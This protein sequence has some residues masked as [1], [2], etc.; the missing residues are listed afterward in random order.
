[1]RNNT[2]KA[3]RVVIIG[4]GG[5]GQVVADH[6]RN[7]VDN[8]GPIEVIG[9]LDDDVKLHHAVLNNLSVLGRVD[10][11]PSIDHD[12]VVVAIGDNC[13]R[14]QMFMQLQSSGE[15]FAVVIHSSAA[16]A[17]DVII[18][19]GSQVIAG[20]TINI[21]ARIGLNTIVNT[22]CTIDHHNQI[23]NHVHIAPGVKLGGEVIVEDDVFIGI[24]ATVIPRCRIGKGSCVGAG[25]VVLSDV[26][27]GET[28]YGVP[29]KQRNK[30]RNN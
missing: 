29:A 1:M 16:I 8:H 13:R 7:C 23:G 2:N 4:A 20:S 22:G 25:S 9:F 10:A 24:G 6:I 21:G 12:A 27:A 14:R 28:V 18:G 19:S 5:H 11:L 26:V 17:Q 15:Q 3:Q 30:V